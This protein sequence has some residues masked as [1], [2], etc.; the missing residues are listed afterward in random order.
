MSRMS[1][2]NAN[3]GPNSLSAKAG[4]QDLFLRALDSIL[5]VDIQTGQIL[6]ANDASEGVFQMALE[7]LQGTNIYQYCREDHLPE[8]KK[9]IRIA[10]RRYH[11]KTFEI[12]M[13]VGEDAE[14][15]HITGEMAAS[16]LKLG[17]GKEVLQLIFRDITEKKEAERKIAEYIGQIEEANK[18]LEELATTDGMTGLINFR[19]LMKLLEN[20]HV[21]AMR[22]KS[23]YAIIFC[24]IDHFKQYNDHNGHPAGDALLKRFADILRSCV[25]NTDFPARYGGEEFVV[26]CPETNVAESQIVAERI[27][28]SVANTKFPNGEKQPIGLVSVSIGVSGFP[29]DGNDHKGI[30]EAADQ[31]LYQSKI[32]GRNRVMLTSQI[33]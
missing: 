6:E 5:L 33:Q 3:G 2:E 22:Y 20:E 1:E 11:P 21:R 10:S 26:L 31:M 16:P 28:N 30:L 9:D 29:H 27:R 14:K 18:K 13:V 12:P 23:E 4:Y 32:N 7:K 19:Q 24:D 15:I 25:R 8:F 17:D